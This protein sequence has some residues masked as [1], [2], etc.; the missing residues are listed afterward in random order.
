MYLLQMYLVQVQFV[1]FGF[2]SPTSAE[3]GKQI[4][5]LPSAT[6]SKPPHP[7]TE[8]ADSSSPINMHF[9]LTHLHFDN[10]KVLILN[11]HNFSA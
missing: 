3:D 6:T 8:S 4:V 2:V 1:L 10:D 5:S 9:T 11:H 7:I